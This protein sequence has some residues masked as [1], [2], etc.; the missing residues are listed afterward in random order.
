MT[1]PSKTFTSMV[2]GF[3]FLQG[4]VKN[5][6]A[7]MP[8]VGQWIAPTLDPEELDKRIN[9]LKTVQFWLEQ[10]ARMLATTIQALEVQRMTLS[11][12]KTM[13]VS[14]GD[15]TE[16]LKIRMPA[17]TPRAAAPTPPPPPSPPPAPAL[18]R[19]A[20]A[21]QLQRLMRHRR[22]AGADP[23]ARL[24]DIEQGDASAVV[25]ELAQR[26]RDFTRIPDQAVGQDGVVELGAQFGDQA[27]DRFLR[28]RR[29][30]PYGRADSTAS[31]KS[32]RV[33]DR[34][35]VWPSQRTIAFRIRRRSRFS[36]GVSDSVCFTASSSAISCRQSPRSRRT[37]SQRASRALCSIAWARVSSA[38]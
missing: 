10:N 6:G 8:G 33:D 34:R 24:A 13:N 27:H 5:A 38:R 29:Q 32:T 9:D 14:F 11:T 16:A 25:G 37:S 12:L 1:D 4:L 18:E 17:E 26:P 21:D 22:Q 31:K 2:P 3:D 23:A 20:A 28:C 36:A 15:L 30:R 7:A 19:L 35:R